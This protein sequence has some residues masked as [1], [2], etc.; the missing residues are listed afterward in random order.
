MKDNRYPRVQNPSD[1]QPFERRCT[2]LLSIKNVCHFDAKF[3][4]LSL[5]FS[6]QSFILFINY[7]IS[8]ISFHYILFWFSLWWVILFIIFMHLYVGEM[9]FFSIFTHIEN[10]QILL[11]DF[12]KVILCASVFTDIISCVPW[13]Y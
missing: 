8:A 9:F 5:S 11:L 10:N 7:C 2:I 1:R 12:F 13:R 3:L 6:F 4:F